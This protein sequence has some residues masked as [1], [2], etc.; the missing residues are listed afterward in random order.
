MSSYI[1][2]ASF[3]LRISTSVNN[4]YNWY[5]PYLL[6]LSI[7]A[8]GQQLVPPITYNVSS[9]LFLPTNTNYVL[10]YMI[11]LSNTSLYL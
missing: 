2:E 3:K 8:L 10:Q 4:Y 11:M 6:N 9:L 7:K 5:P 1:A